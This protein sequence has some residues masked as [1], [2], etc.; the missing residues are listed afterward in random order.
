MKINDI[1][2][3]GIISDLRTAGRRNQAQ[4]KAAAGQWIKSQAGRLVPQGVKSAYQNLQQ[5][6]QQQAR[7]PEPAPQP[8]PQPAPMGFKIPVGRRLQ[9]IDP[10][11][12]GKYFKDASGRWSNE[13][14]QRIRRRSSI[15]YLEKLATQTKPVFVPA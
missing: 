9:I 14:G 11:S 2:T 3:E 10:Q 13:A 7:G 5:Y 1:I 12:R 4:M 15:N 6:A 8:A